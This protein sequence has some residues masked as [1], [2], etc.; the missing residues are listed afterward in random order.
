MGVGAPVQRVRRALRPGPRRARVGDSPKRR[1][2]ARGELILPHHVDTPLYG[3]VRFGEVRVVS[4]G[5]VRRKTVD[6]IR[7]NGVLSSELV[8]RYTTPVELLATRRTAIDW[9][10]PAD[11]PSWLHGSDTAGR[12]NS[13]VY[14]ALSPRLRR[15]RIALVCLSCL[16]ALALAAWSWPIVRSGPG[17]MLVYALAN[18][19]T[20]EGR[21]SEALSLLETSVRM[22]PRLALAHN[23]AGVIYYQQGQA[24]RAAEAFRRAAEADPALAVAQNNLGLIYLEQEESE[25]AR[26]VLRRA[27]AL[28]PENAAMLINLGLAE[29]LAGYPEEAIRA[30]R[31]ALRESPHSLVA[32]ANLGTLYYQREQFPEARE[33][34]ESALYRDPYL[35]HARAMLGAIALSEG[36]RAG[37]WD[38]LQAARSGLEGDPI[39]H[40]YLALW[41]EESG[42]MARVEE[43]LQQTLALQPHPDLAALV[44]SHLIAVVSPH[45]ELSA[46]RADREAVDAK[47]E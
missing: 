41:Y 25:Q 12:P 44:R 43:E 29:Q 46:A 8:A 18:R 20:R 1:V 17:A 36:D 28:N 14:S 9:W 26:A 7:A 6:H 30:Y 13:H 2:Y 10:A 31:A 40:F 15:R 27:V 3:H 16:L 35:P 22:N 23:D 11:P 42:E 37:A 19:R 32:Q 21:S 34:L 33:H 5:R 39:Y 24:E 47:G 45:K 4:V 38:E